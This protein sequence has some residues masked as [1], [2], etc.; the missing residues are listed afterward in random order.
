MTTRP[1]LSPLAKKSPVLSNL[2]AEMMSAKEQP[3]GAVPSETS[4]DS[5][6]SPKH[7]ANFHSGYGVGSSR[8]IDEEWLPRGALLSPLL[9]CL[10]A[11]LLDG[12]ESVDDEGLLP[13]EIDGVAMEPVFMGRR[14]SACG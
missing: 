8:T 5:F 14:R 4:A 1:A 13:R 9:A 6:L 10:M 2:I 12:E 3:L 11:F 7:W